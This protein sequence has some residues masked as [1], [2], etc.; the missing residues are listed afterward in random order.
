MVL[1]LALTPSS[2]AWVGYEGRIGMALLKESLSCDLRVS[3]FFC[4]SDL[5][6]DQFA[7]SI[8]Q[9]RVRA[10]HEARGRS[11]K[12]KGHSAAWW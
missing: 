8:W 6:W 12:T 4:L 9:D 7:K 11:A 3:D 5:P 1:L 10:I 2:I